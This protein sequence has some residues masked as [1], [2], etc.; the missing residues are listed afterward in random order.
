MHDPS[1][2]EN[3]DALGKLESESSVL[4]H[5]NDR[6]IP[7]FGE[8]AECIHQQVTDDRGEALKRLVQEKQP[9][10]AHLRPRDGQH[11]L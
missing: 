2:L 9:G 6:A 5:Q 3:E 8:L 7:G 11:L 4:L 10:L 1:L